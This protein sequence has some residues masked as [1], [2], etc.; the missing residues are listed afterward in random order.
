VTKK[1]GLNLLKILDYALS[2][3]AYIPLI[4]WL[5]LREASRWKA[6]LIVA[7]QKIW[8]HIRSHILLNLLTVHREQVYFLHKNS[9]KS[10]LPEQLQNICLDYCDSDSAFT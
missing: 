7:P 8:P 3:K 1:R 10:P 2:D 6:E 9:K 5:A 4:L